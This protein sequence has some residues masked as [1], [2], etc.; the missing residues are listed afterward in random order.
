MAVI[1]V[2]VVGVFFFAVA[3]V[4]IGAWA[5]AYFVGATVAVTWRI[6]AIGIQT[7]RW[8]PDTPVAGI[9]AAPATD[10]PGPTAT[11][12]DPGYRHYFLGPGLRDVRLLMR[13][14][15]L[16]GAAWL[17]GADVPDRYVSAGRHGRRPPRSFLP[18]RASRLE[19]IRKR[20]EP[21]MGDEP[22]VVAGSLAET[23]GALLGALVAALLL[24]GA[25]AVTA[26]VLTAAG[27]TVAVAALVLRACER[28]SLW[29]RGITV[30]CPRCHDRVRR[31]VYLCAN[32]ACGARHRALLPGRLGVLKRYCRCRAALPTLLLNGK[33]RLRSRCPDCKAVLPADGLAAR[34]VHL[35]LAAGSSAGKTAFLVAAMS[36]LAARESSTASDFRLADESLSD[37]LRVLGDAVDTGDLARIPG[38]RHPDGVLPWTFHVGNGRGQRLAYAYDPA[39]EH[40]WQQ[41]DLAGW[42]FLDLLTGVVLV[43]D[44]F[45]LAGLS[46]LIGDEMLG[47][48]RPCRVPPGVVLDCVTGELR[49]RHVLPANG[50]GAPLLAV[51]LTKGDVLAHLPE[52]GHP[53]ERVTAQ[54]ERD[55]AVQEWL[56]T[57]AGQRNLVASIQLT[58]PRTR[59]RY[60]VTS[61]HGRGLGTVV[62]ARS[63]TPIVNDDPADVLLWLMGGER[64]PA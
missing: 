31:P 12:P 32:P 33:G 59:T 37:Q 4:L 14:V 6:L 48:V 46:R 41:D 57:T 47:D 52:P 11:V 38:T 42:D 29:L 43:I 62:S 8:N 56:R 5:T 63:G 13:D 26:V 39:G 22:Y 15:C 50:S 58:F 1:L 44:P 2:F 30:E 25:W 64:R 17:V 20:R 18:P 7:A 10:V 35:L 16:L 3:I 36:R 55:A 21:P 34:T 54:A 51:V 9:A 24:L 28:A 19:R 40:L 53:F 23:A 49:Q 60:F 27:L 45:S 61:A